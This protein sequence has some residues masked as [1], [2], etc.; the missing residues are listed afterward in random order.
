VWWAL[1]AFAGTYLWTVLVLLLLVLG[2]TAIVRPRVFYGPFTLL[3]L[4]LAAW[5]ALAALQ[6]V[7]VSPAVRLALSPASVAVERTLRLDANAEVG[8]APL[9]IDPANTVWALAVAVSV[10]LVFWSARR[11]LAH[12]SPRTILRGVAAAG[13]LAAP[14]AIVQHAMAPKLLYGYF[15]PGARNVIPYTPFWN[16]NDLA[17]WLIMAAPLTL[18]YGLAR[19]QSA[20]ARASAPDIESLLDP[21]TTWLGASIVLMFGAL[22]ATT[23]RSGLMGGLVALATFGWL[24]RRQLPPKRRVWLYAAL[25]AIVCAAALYGNT[26]ALTKRFDETVTQGVAGRS[27]IWEDTMVIVRNFFLTGTGIGSFRHAMLAYQRYPRDFMFNHAHNEYLQIAA[28]GG[29]ML[30]IPSLVAALSL[31]WLIV[32]RLRHDRSSFY[33][34]RAGAVSGIIAVAVQSIWDT[35]LKLPANGVLFAVLAA[36]ALTEP[37]SSAPASRRD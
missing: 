31:L 16:R 15:P 33:W 26:I 19:I 29:L 36:I 6:L 35:G 21:T 5:L 12:R 27:A 17:T 4:S 13:L 8:R 22:I 34:I 32:G 9:S 7:P 10:V 30:S 28:E 25:A 14:I 23:S 1:F 24:A 18:G 20:Y 2:L 3:D 11:V 37:A